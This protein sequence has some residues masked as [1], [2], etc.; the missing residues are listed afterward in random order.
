MYCNLLHENLVILY[1]HFHLNSRSKYLKNKIS[2]PV[3]QIQVDDESK[4][5]F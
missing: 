4:L 2:R 5:T 3:C 1:F